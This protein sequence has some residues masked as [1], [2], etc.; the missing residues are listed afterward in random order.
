MK[1]AYGKIRFPFWSCFPIWPKENG[2]CH[3]AA[4]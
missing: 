1:P 2:W 4:A 3:P